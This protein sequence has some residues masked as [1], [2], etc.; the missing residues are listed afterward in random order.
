[1]SQTPTPETSAGARGILYDESYALISIIKNAL[2][3]NLSIAKLMILLDRGYPLF[4]KGVFL[5][6]AKILYIINSIGTFFS[7]LLLGNFYSKYDIIYNLFEEAKPIYEE[8]KRIGRFLLNVVKMIFSS[9]AEIEDDEETIEQS[10]SN[11]D[12]SDEQ[13]NIRGT[14]KLFRVF[15]W[16]V[17]TFLF[18][19]AL[20]IYIIFE[21]ILQIRKYAMILL[22]VFVFLMYTASGG[23][24]GNDFF[25]VYSFA[26]LFV[27]FLFNNTSISIVTIVI[28]GT[29]AY[30]DS[31]FYIYVA[32][33]VDFL[34]SIVLVTSIM[35]SNTINTLIPKLFQTKLTIE[36]AFRLEDQDEEKQDEEVMK[37]T[38]KNLG[39][40]EEE[41]AILEQ[42][43]SVTDEQKEEINKRSLWRSVL[44]RMKDHRLS[45]HEIME[46]NEQAENLKADV[47]D[48][49]RMKFNLFD[50]TP[51]NASQIKQRYQD[52]SERYGIEIH[53]QEH[54]KGANDRI[55]KALFLAFSITAM[56]YWIAISN[57]VLRKGFISYFSKGVV[58]ISKSA[59]YW[60]HTPYLYE[61]T[62]G[63]VIYGT[64]YILLIFLVLQTFGGS[65]KRLLTFVGALIGLI[66]IPA[67]IS[68][69]SGRSIT[70][71]TN[72]LQSQ[73]HFITDIWSYLHYVVLKNILIF[74]SS[75]IYYVTYVLHYL[76]VW[77]LSMMRSMTTSQITMTLAS[78]ILI[79]IITALIIGPIVGYKM[80]RNNNQ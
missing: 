36:Q 9:D 21:R 37:V 63:Y 44:L 62:P 58:D 5:F 67:I 61:G 11:Q 51:Q 77:I 71:F 46:I 12:L 78:W 56:V 41:I 70:E 35:A 32:Q 49:F 68:I 65:I 38:E 24:V 8:L 43:F 31:P 10:Q 20:P 60:L 34:F 74:A 75:V 79:S 52:L 55:F 39:F 30:I 25:S 18:T 69:A 16:M 66:C 40:D 42:G 48:W 73:F 57:V 15:G 80:T 17:K 19:L 54:I 29:L 2:K 3:Y 59:E 76:L 1:M 26:L 50:I 22:I 7:L 27:M 64:L 4:L 45:I 28:L 47:L 13:K 14:R 53:Q 33:V 72:F 6:C 23:L